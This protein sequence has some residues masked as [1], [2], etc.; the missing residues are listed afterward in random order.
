MEGDDAFK[1][2][3]FVEGALFDAAMQTN[4][5]CKSE[6]KHLMAKPIKPQGLPIEPGRSTGFIGPGFKM[7]PRILRAPL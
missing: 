7:F 4:A 1:V 2:L 3:V 6:G 5:M